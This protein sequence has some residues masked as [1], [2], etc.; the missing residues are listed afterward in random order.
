MDYLIIYDASDHLL[1]NW[2]FTA[3]GLVFVAIGSLLVFSP[4]FRS[5]FRPHAH[6]QFFA[7]FSKFFLGF[8]MVWTI[9]ASIDLF[10]GNAEAAN[11]SKKNTCLIA[12]GVV[13]DFDP[14]PYSGHK[15]ESFTVDGVRFE[16]S[17]Y[18]ITGGYNNTVSHGGQVAEGRT[19]RLC[20][21]ERG[22]TRSNII[23][24][25]EVAS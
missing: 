4:T 10:F 17:D 8:A 20:Y 25:V 12:E 9:A 5:L 23:V 15:N 13:Q 2:H 11:A 1:D 16:Y 22:R 6:P 14:M 19:V 21:I 24:R 18:A 7:A 3:I